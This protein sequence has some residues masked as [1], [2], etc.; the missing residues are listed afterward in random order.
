MFVCGGGDGQVTLVAPKTATPTVMEDETPSWAKDDST[1]V[2]LS[3]PTAAKAQP[4]VPTPDWAVPE[5]AE[6]KPEPEPEPAKPIPKSVA[7]LAMVVIVSFEGLCVTLPTLRFSSLS[8]HISYL[9]SQVLF[10]SGVHAP[11]YLCMGSQTLV[12]ISLLVLELRA[13]VRC[14]KSPLRHPLCAC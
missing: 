4:Q 11:G 14:G 2:D 12:Y 13:L 3:A 5:A 1:E 6:P 8:A 10:V 9:F 7:V